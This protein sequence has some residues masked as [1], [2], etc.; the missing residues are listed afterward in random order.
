ME[1]LHNEDTRNIC[2]IQDVVRHVRIR[3][4]HVNGMDDNRLAK[5]AK[6]GNQTIPNHLASLQNV[7]ARVGHQHHRRTDTLDKIQDM[8]PKENEEEEEPS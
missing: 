7:G 2:E 4:D 1:C 8:V 6:M 3:R 5:M